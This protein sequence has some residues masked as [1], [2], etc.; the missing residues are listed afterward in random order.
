MADVS[1]FVA[2]TV[3]VMIL[4]GARHALDIDHIAAIDNLV[5]MRSVE[6]RSRW[7]GSLFSSGH[8]LAV[9]AEMIAL[10]YAVKS[11]EA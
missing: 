2:A 6:R 3:P 11:L 4:L 7:I 5:R 9:C 10:V 1:F 8:M